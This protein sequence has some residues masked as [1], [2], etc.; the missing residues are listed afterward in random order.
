M[1][2]ISWSK[3]VMKEFRL[4]ILVLCVFELAISSAVSARAL[5]Q[6][7]TAPRQLPPQI[8]PSPQTPA[9]PVGQRRAVP[10]AVPSAFAFANISVTVLGPNTVKIEWTPLDGADLY[11]VYR[12]G[13]Q[14]GPNYPR[15]P[16]TPAITVF[17]YSAPA[18]ARS[19]Y[20]VTASHL[21][22]VDGLTGTP[23]AGRSTTKEILLQTSNLVQAVT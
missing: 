8:V 4:V 7:A 11:R 21:T 20:N 5:R 16:G 17:D 15:V 23:N 6:T 22:T 3:K 10:V 2:K 1:S 12:N 13:A 18:N 9:A 14:I 19:T